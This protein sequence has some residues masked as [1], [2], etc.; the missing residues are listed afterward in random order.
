MVTCRKRRSSFLACHS[1]YMAVVW[2]Y[3]TFIT[4][5]IPV[6]LKTW[7]FL[8]GPLIKTT[9]LTSWFS[10][11]L[12][13]LVV[14]HTIS[15]GKSLVCQESTWLLSQNMPPETNQILQSRGLLGC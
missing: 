7:Q 5:P 12:G 14:F 11:L 13:Q 15:T 9:Q 8:R 2:Y 1:T 10:V 3:I 4:L 6:F